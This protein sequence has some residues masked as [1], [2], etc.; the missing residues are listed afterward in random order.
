MILKLA[1]HNI[2]FTLVHKFK[3]AELRPKSKPFYMNVDTVMR[4]FF[5]HIDTRRANIKFKPKK[6]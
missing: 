3:D 1:W 5:V 2:H 6:L 4:I